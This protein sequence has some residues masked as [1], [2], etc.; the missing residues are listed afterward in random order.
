MLAVLRFWFT[1][2][3]VRVSAPVFRLGAEPVRN[4]SKESPANHITRLWASFSAWVFLFYL[5][6]DHKAAV[7]DCLM[8]V[9][10]GCPR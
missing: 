2:D 6:N 4:T 3:L 9:L 1:K 8:K 7:A 10:L 5:G